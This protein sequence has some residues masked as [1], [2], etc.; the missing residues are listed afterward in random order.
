MWG[1]GWLAAEGWGA[2][3]RVCASPGKAG[4]SSCPFS[5]TQC[6]RE[7]RVCFSHCLPNFPIPRASSDF[8]LH[9][10]RYRS[11]VSGILA[12]NMPFYALPDLLVAA[13]GELRGF[14]LRLCFQE[15]GFCAPWYRGALKLSCRTLGILVQKLVFLCFSST[16]ALMLCLKH[17][18]A[19]MLQ[20]GG[21][22]PVRS[23]PWL[24]AL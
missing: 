16:Q 8:F 9:S 22:V 21:A 2:A 11:W 20:R 23:E 24:R 12:Q 17:G 10:L 13:R 19:F 4:D 6:H 1:W 5:L 3:R 14:L 18:K 15:S 7:D